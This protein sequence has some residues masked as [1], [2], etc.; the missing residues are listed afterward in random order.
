MVCT[1]CM[2]KPN[3]TWNNNIAKNV[4]CMTITWLILQNQLKQVYGLSGTIHQL[5]K[6]LTQDM[7]STLH[8]IKIYITIRSESFISY[9]LPMIMCE[10]INYCM[11]FLVNMELLFY[12]DL[13]LIKTVFCELFNNIQ[14]PWEECQVLW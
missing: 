5:T 6:V 8:L 4:M 11:T 7:F 9:N 14:S 10:I 13:T 12:H 2:S 3:F 1:M